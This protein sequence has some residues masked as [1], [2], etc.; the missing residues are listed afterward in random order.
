MMMF[1]LL[2]ISLRKKHYKWTKFKVMI[3]V[4]VGFAL[5]FSITFFILRY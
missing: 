1:L 3:T 2:I 4:I 5:M